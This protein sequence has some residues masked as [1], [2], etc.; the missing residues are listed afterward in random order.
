MSEQSILKSQI[1]EF[2]ELNELYLRK[3]EEVNEIKSK[4]NELESIINNQLHAMKLE[5]KTFILNNHKIQQKTVINYQQFSMK[6]INDCL[7]DILGEDKMDEVITILKNNRSKKIK[8]EL[9]L[10]LNE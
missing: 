6:Y 10:S 4:K 5:N 7:S 9:K 2:I 1:Q 3:M 8:K